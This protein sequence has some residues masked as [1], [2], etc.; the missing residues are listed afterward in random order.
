MGDERFVPQVFDE[1]RS[2]MTPEKAQ[3]LLGERQPVTVSS[4][5]DLRAF[6]KSW[7]ERRALE[8]ALARWERIFHELNGAGFDMQALTESFLGLVKDHKAG[9][10]VR[11]LVIQKR[12]P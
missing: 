4:R 9:A 3:E 12:A 8:L 11:P 7:E 5:G 10:E 1:D 2:N 6:S